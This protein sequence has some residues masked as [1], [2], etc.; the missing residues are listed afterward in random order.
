[1][2]DD[3]HQWVR[4]SPWE[5]LDPNMK[6]T[7]DGPTSGPGAIYAWSG[8]SKVGQGR[9]TIVESKAGQSVSMKLEMFKPF[10]CTN[11][12]TFKLAPSEAGTRVSWIMEGQNG[13]MAKGFSLLMNM[14][15]MCGT[16]FEEGLA[17]LNRVAQSKTPENSKTA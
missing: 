15:K 2:I 17:N 8:N 13:F 11:R 7:F 1:M 3:F 4:W 9:S 16:I 12:V 14:D 5:K 6:R 10:N